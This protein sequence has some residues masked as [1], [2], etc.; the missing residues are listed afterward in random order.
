[1]GVDAADDEQRCRLHLREPRTD[2]VE[3]AA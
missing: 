2:Q 1:V 3:P